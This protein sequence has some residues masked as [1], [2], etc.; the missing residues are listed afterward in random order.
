MSTGTNKERIEQNNTLLEEIKNQVS[1]LPE[2]QNIK[3]IKRTV[4]MSEEYKTSA[5]RPYSMGS[6]SSI[7]DYV[8]I[9]YGGSGSEV[10]YGTVKIYNKGVLESTGTYNQW[11]SN[12]RSSNALLT[13]I[14]FSKDN[15][16]IYLCCPYNTTAYNNR[17]SY[18]S[19]S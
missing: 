14:K 19:I 16:K 17:L 8:F 9:P 2:Y 13:P 15:T 7:G 10:P 18:G 6:I 11:V 5:S 12:S 1:N 4:D 3:E